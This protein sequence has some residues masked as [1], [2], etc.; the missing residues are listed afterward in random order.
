[1][2]Y[3]SGLH[4]A[5]Y[6]EKWLQ[7]TDWQILHWMPEVGAHVIVTL[8]LM[9]L[10]VKHKSP[11]QESKKKNKCTKSSYRNWMTWNRMNITIWIIFPNSRS[12]HI[13]SHQCRNSTFEKTSQLFIWYTVYPISTC[14]SDAISCNMND[15]STSKI[16]ISYPCPFWP[17][18]NTSI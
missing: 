14:Y 3:L 15:S 18:G 7:P 8:I 9:S 6:Q 16:K 2:Q 17:N 1:M 5:F 13:W 4:M 11:C 12:D 10:I